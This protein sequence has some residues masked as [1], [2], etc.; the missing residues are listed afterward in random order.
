VPLLKTACTYSGV[1]VEFGIR[2]EL[3]HE[4]IQVLGA[5]VEVGLDEPDVAHLQKNG[6]KRAA[7]K[8]SL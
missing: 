8:A 2:E 6:D 5:G 4:L 7:H 1:F 3:H